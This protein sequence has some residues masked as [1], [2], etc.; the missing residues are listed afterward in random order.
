M[1]MVEITEDRIKKM[2]E[3]FKRLERVRYS[4]Y[5]VE[6]RRQLS[7]Q[8]K[9]QGL[10]QHRIAKL[11]NVSG[12]MPIHY[13]RM[14]PREDCREAI[15]EFL[16]EWIENELYPRSIYKQQHTPVEIRW[17]EYELSGPDDL[18]PGYKKY[19]SRIPKIK[20]GSNFDSFIDN[21]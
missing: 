1:S 4:D 3:Y 18:I 7:L 8:L 21:L 11:L 16:W 14:T 19:K 20:R 2:Y 13:E 10:T 17:M 15:N 5:V 9:K 12:T 6:M